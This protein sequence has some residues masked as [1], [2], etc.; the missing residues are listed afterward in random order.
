MDSIKTE[1]QGRLWI[2]KQDHSFIG[3]GRVELLEKIAQY[4]SIA[5]AAKAMKMSYKAAWD[6]VDAMNNLAQES[7]VICS[8]GGKGGGGT[9]VTK[10]GHQLIATFRA[11]EAEH[12]QFLEQ[13]S[14]QLEKFDHFYQLMK[15]INMSTSARNQFIGTVTHIK[16]GQVSAEIVLKLKGNDHIVATITQE[17][18]KRLGLQEGSEAYVLIKAPHVILVPTDSELEF[19]ARNRLCGKVTRLIGGD[20]VNAEVVLELAG[21]NTLKAVVT[22]E[23]VAELGIKEGQALCG[24][25]KASHVI[26]AVKKPR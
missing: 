5:K 21:G 20:A 24:I 18:V 14:Q 13:L 2:T 8:S 19:S 1:I 26:L 10:Y 3:R 12:Q 7:L 6:A 11:I 15:H 17:S 22:Q 23:A 16:I 4:G 9:Q 25:V